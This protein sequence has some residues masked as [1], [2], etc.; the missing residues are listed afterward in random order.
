[1]VVAFTVGLLELCG[2]LGIVSFPGVGADPRPLGSDPLPLVDLR[3]ETW[4]DIAFEW[5]DPGPPMP[6]HYK[7]DR[8]GSRNEIDRE[9]ADLYL[10]GDS[11]VVA[12][13]VP[14]ERTLTA[15]LEQRLGV[16]TMNIALIGLGL[17]EQ[18]ELFLKARVPLEGRMVLQFVFEGNDLVDSARCRGLLAEPEGVRALWH[19]SFTY[20]SLLWLQHKS[21]PR[22]AG[23]NWGILGGRDYLFHW[24]ANSFEHLETELPHIFATL[25][26]Q[27]EHVSASGGVL[28]IVYVPA[29]LRV[30][31]P[32]CEWPA[33]SKIQDMP[34]HLNPL[35]EELTDW[36][37]E[38]GIPMLDCTEPLQAAA[39]SGSTPFFEFDT[40]LN[41]AGHDVLAEAIAQWPF[42]SEFADRI[43][44]NVPR[45]SGIRP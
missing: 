40:H 19:N 13:L 18:R 37:A 36:C 5:P 27:H 23:L 32:L 34:S 25:S 20:N 30:V 7:T 10:I 12:A 39:A 22:I 28:G 17:Q 1:M 44:N 45:N 43:G 8:R 15:Q 24:T 14:F 41:E 16:E 42:V 2:V 4:Q 9:S 21:D 3:G 29:K 11:I 33:L 26:D 35:R 31:G 38:Q 6:F